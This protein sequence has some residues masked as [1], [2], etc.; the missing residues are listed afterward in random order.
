MGLGIVDGYLVGVVIVVPLA[1]GRHCYVLRRMY[2][3]V[4]LFLCYILLFV[5]LKRILFIDV[6]KIPKNP[7]KSMRATLACLFT[8]VCIAHVL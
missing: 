4:L 8:C 1:V 5:R 6:E 7:A 2:F 3:V